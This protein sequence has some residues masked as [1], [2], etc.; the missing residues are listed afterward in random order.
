MTDV[1]DLSRGGKTTKQ[2]VT[3]ILAPGAPEGEAPSIPAVK[4][5]I[6]IPVFNEK[7]TIEAILDRIE[8]T[9]FD[10]EIIVVDDGSTDGTR[11]I[12]KGR[13]EGKCKILYHPENQGKGAALQTGFDE[14][15]GD[16]VIIQDADLEYD[17][18]DYGKL[19]DPILRG[20]ADV[21][22]GSRFLGGPHRVLFFWHFMGNKALTLFSNMLNNINLS[23]METCYKVFK[24]DILKN[25]R[26]RSKRFGFEPEFTAKVARRRLKI[27]E[28]PI[29]Y[30]GRTYEEGKKITW[31]D[32]ISALYCIIKYR[33]FD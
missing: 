21:V 27:F 8:Q 26:F 25:L 30:Y 23:D 14:V 2:E 20:K 18:A 15:S 31:K 29:S 32:G 17:P 28:I 3:E 9:G 4:L 22:F 33:F 6:V 19:I 7:D 24:S 12:L 5:S 13:C 10:K 11:E 16:I 1:A